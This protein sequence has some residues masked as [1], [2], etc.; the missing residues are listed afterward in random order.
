MENGLQT[1]AMLISLSI[2]YWSARKLDKKESKRVT[3][4]HKVT[5]KAARVTKSL[6]PEEFGSY[7][8]IANA[9]VAARQEHYRLTLPW[10]DG[11]SRILLATQYESY[12]EIMRPLRQDFDSASKEFMQQY[13]SLYESAKRD[14]K[15]LWKQEDYP[16][17]ADISG[18]FYFSIRVLPLPEADDFRVNLE[19]TDVELIRDQIREDTK[20]S[21]AQAMKDPYRRLL[22][23]VSN[24][25]K[26]LNDKKG[27]FHDTLVTNI[28]DMV[29]L[30]PALNLMQDPELT[31]MG[32]RVL[33]S[34]TNHEPDTLRKNIKI[35]KN[36]GQQADQICNDLAA[37][38]AR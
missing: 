29:K 1:K 8:A 33:A 17:V 10:T 22:E 37:F 5:D 3:E 7:K 34:L 36:V 31:K 20:N 19:N 12:S 6:L 21:I 35:R 18:K 11:G 9:N 2:G 4:H 27:K 28:E 16:S 14:L 30:L 26:K 13:P 24:M 38:M 25:A 23:V 15:T 32:K